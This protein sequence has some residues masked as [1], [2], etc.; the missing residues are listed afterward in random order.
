MQKSVA[1][2]KSLDI[3]KEEDRNTMN[4][5]ENNEYVKKNIA[6]IWDKA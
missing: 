5:K 3:I 6:C 1:R 2:N 4:T